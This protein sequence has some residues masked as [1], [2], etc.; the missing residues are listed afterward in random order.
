MAG[1]MS[2][3]GLCSLVEVLREELSTFECQVGYVGVVGH[4]MT[5]VACR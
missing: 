1:A 4:S 5:E 3:Q 2:K